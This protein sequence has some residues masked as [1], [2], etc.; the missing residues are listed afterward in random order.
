VYDAFNFARKGNGV[1]K[2]ADVSQMK[3]LTLVLSNTKALIRYVAAKFLPLHI[4]LILL[5]M[6][7][8]G[9][10]ATHTRIV[11]IILR[12]LCLS[13]EKQEEQKLQSLTIH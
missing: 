13:C 9:N 7:K 11:R 1:S 4:A 12:L 8:Q 10:V 2:A 3:N 5:V 6:F